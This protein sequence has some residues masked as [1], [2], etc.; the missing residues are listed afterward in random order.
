MLDR[1][2]TEVYGVGKEG[3]KDALTLGLK[4]L[5]DALFF[6]P[7][8]YDDRREERRISSTTIEN[9]YINCRVTVLSRTHFPTRN[10]RTLKVTVYDDDNRRLDLLCFNRD[11]LERTLTIGSSWYIYAKVEKGSGNATSASFEL[12]AKKEDTGLGAILPL[13]SLSGS[14]TMKT[15]RRITRYALKTL[16]PLEEILP[17]SITERYR[18][19]SFNSALKGI[20]Y[21]DSI[22]TATA[23]RRTLSYIELLIMELSVL[24]GRTNEVRKKSKEGK[25]EKALLSSLPFSLTPDQMAAVEEIR[26]DLDSPYAT[27]RLLQ[28]DV[29][30]GKTLVAWVTALHVIERKE[31]VAF[32]APTELLSVQH[33]EGAQS[34]LSP[35]GVKVALL[36]GE[37][38]G[39]ERKEILSKIKSGEYDIVIGT[40][41]LFSEDVEY[42]NLKFI[43]V[44]EQHRFGVGQRDALIKKGSSPHILSMSA[45]PIPRTLALTL[46]ADMD[47]STIKT[48]PKGRKEIVTYTVGPNSRDRMYDSIG[49][50]FSRGHQAYFVY[51]RIDDEGNSELRDVTTMFDFLK[52]KYPGIPSALLHSRLS[53]EEKIKILN[54]FK[55]GKISYIVSTTVVEVGLDIPNATCMVIEHADRFGLAQLHQL[56]GRVGR[57]SL[58]S[59]CFL[60][61]GDGL[62]PEARSRLNALKESNDGFFIAEKDLEIRGPGEISGT[63]QSGFLRLKFASLTEDTKIVECAKK[64][65]EKILKEDPGLISDENSVLRKAL[66]YL[67][68]EC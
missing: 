68:K 46:F 14:L 17:S 59:Y 38:K 26:S 63:E 36:K 48:M 15:M 39:K 34:L 53:E 6:M 65:A 4:T 66:Q 44:D 21:P 40:H 19:M 9:P 10:K 25:L 31:Q 47:I 35:L 43:I 62:T 20:H 30:S 8:A 49:V 45:T 55:D 56:R 50:E 18:L 60:V 33:Y 27:S 12:S 1:A 7:R 23:S 64:D 28:G 13:Y 5:K 54:D 16:L 3:E 67:K 22:E 57:S 24:R 41:A 11:Y 42:R 61:F 58:Q 52:E 32:M 29:G 2:L 37:T 51:P